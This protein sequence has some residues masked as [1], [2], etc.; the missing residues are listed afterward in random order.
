M[1]HGTNGDLELG[2]LAVQN[3][4]ISREELDACVEAQNISSPPRPLS[5]ILLEMQLVTQTQLDRLLK[6]LEKSAAVTVAAAPAPLPPSNLVDQSAAISDL[7]G[8]LAVE[9][10]FATQ[11]QVEECLQEQRLLDSQGQRMR[12]GQI[13]LKRRFL[14]TDQFLEILK[15]Q[16]KTVLVCPSCQAKYLV[17]D[18][19]EPQGGVFRCLAC[20]TILNV[21]AVP[22]AVEAKSGVTVVDAPTKAEVPA[23][24]PMP[25]P[26]PAFSPE[27]TA[28]TIRAQTK[29][30]TV[31]PASTV[32]RISTHD[33]EGKPF[34]RYLMFEPV[35]KGPVGVVYRA[36]DTQR[37]RKVAL[38]MLHEG[39]KDPQAAQRFLREAR[40]AAQLDHPGIV[41][42]FEVGSNEE[43]PY[44]AMEF[45]EG[46]TL[47]KMIAERR[48][49][50]DEMVAILEKASRA[51]DYAHAQG[52]AHR[53]LK[54]SN[55]LVDAM[56]SPHLT[57]FGV[58]DGVDA[59]MSPE[60]ARG[61][62]DSVDAKS[63]L[64]SMGV[65]L[66]EVLTGRKP[67]EADAPV[68]LSAKIQTE[69][70]ERPRAILPEIPR[71]LELIC[72]KAMER[73]RTLRYPSAA[74]LAEDLRRFLEGEP[75]TARPISVVTRLGSRLRR[76]IGVAVALPLLIVL[77][78]G[79]GFFG[80]RSYKD[81]RAKK[82][83]QEAQERR[84]KAKP[85]YADAAKVHEDSSKVVP[86]DRES[87]RD[88]RRNV[89]EILLRLEEAHRL[90][91][92]DNAD[93]AKL[94]DESRGKFQAA[95]KK[96]AG[97]EAE[98]DDLRGL[99]AAGQA[100]YM[101][102]TR[103]WKKE[104]PEASRLVKD[105][106]PRFDDA[107]RLCSR[108]KGWPG[109]HRRLLDGAVTGLDSAIQADPQYAEAY[110]V[111]GKVHM[112][113]GRL[114]AAD[115]DF[116]A[117]AEH[118]A[119]ELKAMEDDP[120]VPKDTTEEFR[121]KSGEL[122]FDW[123]KCL[124]LQ[125]ELWRGRPLL[126]FGERAESLSFAAKETALADQARLEM[127]REFKA[128]LATGKGT[129]VET[130]TAKTALALGGEK[131]EDYK[132]SEAEPFLRDDRVDGIALRMLA[133]S[134]L[135]D[136]NFRKGFEYYHN[137]VHPGSPL[138]PAGVDLYG[139]ALFPR[140]TLEWAEK[141]HTEAIAKEAS[142][143]LH[144]N[145]GVLRQA[146]RR[147]AEAREDFDAALKLKPGD[148]EA[149]LRKINLQLR[150]GELKEA[151]PALNQVAATATSAEAHALRVAVLLAQADPE[152]ALKEI[153]K[154]LRL[155][156][157]EPTLLY[158]RARVHLMRGDP[159]AA[160]FDATRATEALRTFH[161]AFEVR[162]AAKVE[163]RD[164]LG[165]KEDV[166]EAIKLKP[167]YV[168]CYVTRARVR[169]HRN[170]PAGAEQDLERAITM[171]AK[172]AMPYVLRAEFK[173][174]Q[175]WTSS[176]DLL[177]R[178]IR[179]DMNNAKGAGLLREAL[180]LY[181]EALKRDPACVEAEVMSILCRWETADQT[182]LDD[183]DQLVSKHAKAAFVREIH[184]M[185]RF[186]QKKYDDAIADW[187]RAKELQPA[188]KT[189][190]EEYIT[191]ARRAGET[192]KAEAPWLRHFKAAQEFV[193]GN[194]YPG[195]KKEY[196]AGEKLLPKD[197]PTTQDEMNWLRLGAY[198]YACV[199][200]VEAQA[201]KAEA[202]P[203]LIDDAFK[204]LTLSC[205]LGFKFQQDQC[206]GIGSE[207][208][209]ADA[210]LEIL[211]GDLRFKKLLGYTDE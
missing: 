175:V 137:A 99:L 198:N 82:S 39:Q 146:L 178:Q 123:G 74:E 165:A 129:R 168:A 77:F 197:L 202:K 151:I 162:A 172:L 95:A 186:L 169:Y 41:E 112:L 128:F 144:V 73:D 115:Q 191:E 15:L 118:Y 97:A 209:R 27:S 206:H 1:E 143:E 149:A 185:V 152:E 163:V 127:V 166:T 195:A 192:A 126:L 25:P 88:L 138:L 136:R 193:V 204:W 21:P 63:D 96:L 105:C 13:M 79:G 153:E 100:S 80:W 47:A 28:E 7:F 94:L 67:F 55:I 190:F 62:L 147:F 12:L 133:M 14:T 173:R 145:R 50:R 182:A 16:E 22:A 110:H 29:P 156:P 58:R 104:P 167:D 57:D 148:P 26:L 6:L 90:L 201:A 141:R 111:R 10:G 40:V 210:D 121:R 170:E 174:L 196:M 24:P 119:K 61:D 59:Y 69:T 53:N 8:R 18:L 207:H 60:Q 66:Y 189:Q 108:I 19:G 124:F 181:G 139:P 199:L 33:S 188:K 78:G 155:A 171:D 44:F 114:E 140:A 135:R 30:S 194:D 103:T 120:A 54:P 159:G 43:T 92:K 65:I 122:H 11:D 35:G 38:K 85:F 72:L 132:L 157:E 45:V 20:Q 5:Q 49:S 130:Q 113:L 102:A 142:L 180:E 46:R 208:M 2:Q 52:V 36:R 200:A 125:Y 31:R 64:Y 89:D 17:G 205:E 101:Q 86:Q 23:L 106:E 187:T 75:V 51:L 42:I 179:P 9:L 158:L 107:M 56:K 161:H 131:P 32:G 71:E 150:L 83:R 184:G 3:N 91:D 164:F 211:R 37:Q 68:Q 160:M 177:R 98:R 81:W 203:K 176:R 84:N 48:G 109:E 183:L 117:A 76:N 4:F 154:A 116:R 70:P 134:H 93:A 34:G 87:L